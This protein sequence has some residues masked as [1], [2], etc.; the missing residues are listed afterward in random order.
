MERSLA[1]S[2]AALALILVSGCRASADVAQSGPPEVMARI[3]GLDARCK[4]AGGT[5]I[6]NA[7]VLVHDYTGDGRPDFLISEGNYNCSGQPE[8]F[9]PGGQ[10]VVE[11]YMA[12]ADGHA[13][14]VYQGTL[15]GY[16]LVQRTPTL[17]QIARSGA[18][19]G[20]KSPC[21]FDLV[22]NA[23]ASRLEEAPVGTAA[24]RAS[25]APPPAALEE[26]VPGALTPITRAQF[27]SACAL[28]F[29]GSGTSAKDIASACAFRYT[30][31]L[32]SLPL[33]HAMFALR[34]L[35]PE[36]RTYAGIKAAL[37]T[38]RGWSINKPTG[39]GQ[40]AGAQA[41]FFPEVSLLLPASGPVGSVSWEWNDHDMFPYDVPGALRL[42]GAKVTEYACASGGET[43]FGDEKTLQY[44]VE[45]PG[46]APFAVS[47]SGRNG[48]MGGQM[49][50]WSI[51]L[52]LGEPIPSV[53][54]LAAQSRKD[55]AKNDP[56]SAPTQWSTQCSD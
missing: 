21:G 40:V 54:T 46:L 1:T 20:A 45:A 55:D 27:V 3:A 36:Q 13:A 8:L 39:P 19:C 7:Y 5:P 37:P 33:A 14:S 26:V 18:T 25:A 28:E 41:Q 24:K 42:A 43:N 38:V 15:A 11:V 53:A 9:R 4:A 22:W 56:G 32:R 50:Y 12:K 35:P 29:K 6:P 2:V 47:M 44:R 17:I 31:T 49:A 52:A 16:R 34:K 48:A 51:G 10:S 23:A 30:D